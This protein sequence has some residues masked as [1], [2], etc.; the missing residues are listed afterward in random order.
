M[1]VHQCPPGEVYNIGGNRTLTIR[2]VLNMLL[3]LSHKKNEIKIQVD[4]SLLRPSDVTLQIP[5]CSKFK[6]VTGWEP[7][8]PL[9]TTLRDLLDYWRARYVC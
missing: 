2:E 4:P 7:A 1:L 9:E 6:S 5:D 3:A 8:I